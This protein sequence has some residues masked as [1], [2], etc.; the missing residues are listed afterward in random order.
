MRSLNCLPAYMVLMKVS[1]SLIPMTSDTGDTSKLAATR[2]MRDF[3][4]AEAPAIMCVKLNCFCEATISGASLSGRKPSNPLL[5]ATRILVTPLTLE[6]SSAAWNYKQI[7]TQRM[8]MSSGR[9]SVSGPSG[10]NTLA[11][12]DPATKQ[13]ISLPSFDAAVTA[14]RVMLLSL[15]FVCSATTS[16]LFNLFRSCRK[17]QKKRTLIKTR[18]SYSHYPFEIRMLNCFWSWVS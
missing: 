14:F 17:Y 4:K 2:G 5:S 6:S 18:H 8:S 9:I 7:T 12:L 13:V 11:Q 16:V 10:C 15:E 3:P 1:A